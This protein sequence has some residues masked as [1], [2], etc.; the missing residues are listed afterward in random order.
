M[1]EGHS[2]HTQEG[3]L[4]AQGVQMEAK[5]LGEREGPDQLGAE[6]QGGSCVCRLSQRTGLIGVTGS[7][8]FGAGCCSSLLTHSCKSRLG[9][10]RL[11]LKRFRRQNGDHPRRDA[12]YENQHK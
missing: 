9:R 1:E 3:P 12:N 7:M 6:G 4:C 11:L 2:G 5:M 10:R 8:A